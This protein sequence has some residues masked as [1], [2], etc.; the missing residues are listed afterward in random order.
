VRGIFHK[1]YWKGQLK[2]DERGRH[3]AHRQLK[4]WENLKLRDILE[5][6]RTEMVIVLKLI[7]ETKIQV[8][9]LDLFG[10]G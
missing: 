10:S 3:M 2:E 9:E 4:R 8:Y 5:E 6:P 7:L 1:K